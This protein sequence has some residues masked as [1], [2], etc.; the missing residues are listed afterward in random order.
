MNHSLRIGMGFGLSSGVITTLGLMIGLYSS[1]H[2]RIAVI[3]AILTTALADSLSDAF[4]VHTSEESEGVHTHKEVWRSTFFTFIFKFIFSSIFIIPV[5]FLS[6][7]TALI[8]SVAIGVFFLFLFNFALAKAQNKKP[9]P[10][11]SEH[12]FLAIIV[13][14]VSYYLGNLIN[15]IFV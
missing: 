11:I 7:Q 1:T 5:I 13:F 15:E 9:W 4:G 6:L 2:S 12:V 10:V 14:I 3:G 8:T